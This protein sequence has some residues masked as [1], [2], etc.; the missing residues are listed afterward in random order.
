MIVL[1][2]IP[3]AGVRLGDGELHAHDRRK[4]GKPDGC[5]G[6]GRRAFVARYV[7]V[8]I[9][10]RE[11]ALPWHHR[12]PQPSHDREQGSRRNAGGFLQPYWA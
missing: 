7:P 5:R 8:M 10:E 6:R 9:A 4:E 12:L 3:L 1:D 11:S 2:T